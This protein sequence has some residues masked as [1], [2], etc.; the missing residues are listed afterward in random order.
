VPHKPHEPGLPLQEAASDDSPPELE[1]NT[2][3]FFVNRV[4]PHLGQAVPCQRLERTRTSLS[5]PHFSQ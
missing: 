3:N 2:D 1:A 4:A 5:A